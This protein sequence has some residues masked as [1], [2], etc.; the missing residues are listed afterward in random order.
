MKKSLGITV[1]LLVAAL[2]LPP[3]HAKV[4]ISAGGQFGL[5]VSTLTSDAPNFDQGKKSRNG[6]MFGGLI[7]FGFSDYISLQPEV[8]YSMKG[9]RF[10]YD[11]QDQYGNVVAVKET[12]K[13]DY[14]EIPVYFKFSIPTGTLFTPDFFFGP[15]MGIKL[16]GKYEVKW[17]GGSE[18]GTIENLKSLDFGLGFGAGGR[19]AAGPGDAFLNIL[20]NLGLSNLDDSG[21]Q[22]S[23][24]NR[25]LTFAAGYA[26]RFKQK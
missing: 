14:M 18:K 13:I 5:N 1:A 21:G 12:D 9:A 16:S 4:R 25:C 22:Y 15:V 7:N 19:F 8:R 10:D 20:Y 11:A 6:I 2:I 3:A 17:A 23:I 26:F 24:K